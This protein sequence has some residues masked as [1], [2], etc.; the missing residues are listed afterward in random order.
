LG[1]KVR[2]VVALEALS[3][4]FALERRAQ[5]DGKDEASAKDKTSKS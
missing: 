5:N 1:E 3:G 4:F 2:A